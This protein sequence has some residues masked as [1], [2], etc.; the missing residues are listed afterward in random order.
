MTAATF[1][2]FLAFSVLGT[3]VVFAR[4]MGKPF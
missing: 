1:I 3:S 2:I 4:P